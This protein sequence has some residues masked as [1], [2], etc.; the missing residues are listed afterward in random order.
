VTHRAYKHAIGTIC[1]P[2]YNRGKLLLKT[3]KEL[4][5]T[6]GSEWPVLVVDNASTKDRGAYKEIEILA[7]SSSFLYYFRHKKNGLFEG[8]LLSLFDLVQ[9]QFFLVVSD[10]DFPS[11]EALDEMVPFLENNRDIGGIRASLGTLPGVEKGQAV[12]FKDMYFSKG[13]GISLFGLNGNY[14][15]GQ[16]YNAP[17]LNKLNIPQ[18]LKKNIHANQFYPHL[19]LNVLAAANSRTMLSSSIVCYEGTTDAYR[20]EETKDYFGPFSYG[21]RIDQFVALRNALIEAFK[22]SQ[23]NTPEGRFNA[24]GFYKTYIGL[25]SKYCNLVVRV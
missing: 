3:I 22:D 23:N 9:T 7:E 17:L 1:F 6:L 15:S 4:L 5:P 21:N 24:N 16:I 14:I 8:N 19:Y 25:C 11:I 13:E 20:P 10:E 18:R 2:S 12:T